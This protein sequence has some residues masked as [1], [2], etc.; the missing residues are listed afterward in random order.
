MRRCG[1]AH[2]DHAIDGRLDRRPRSPRHVAVEALEGSEP[3]DVNGEA[4]EG[5]EPV[6]DVPLRVLVAGSVTTTCL[7]DSAEGALE[8]EGNRLWCAL[9]TGCARAEG[10]SALAAGL[11][12]RPE[13]ALWSQRSRRPAQR[14]GSGAHP[15]AE[16][17][18]SAKLFHKL[19]KQGEK[20][21][22]YSLSIAPTRL[23]RRNTVFAEFFGIFFLRLLRYILF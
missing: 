13:D 8:R 22:S 11:H 7:N 21:R 14:A 17:N 15:C 9:A 23:R 10:G 18:Q 2:V 5:A 4:G 12:A 3:R 20:P 19:L 6:P 16:S 1:A